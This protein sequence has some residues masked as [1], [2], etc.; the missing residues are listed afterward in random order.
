MQ[1]A[2]VCQIKNQVQA[3]AGAAKGVHEAGDV[4]V[5]R[6]RPVNLCFTQRQSLTLRH[7]QCHSRGTCSSRGDW[8]EEEGVLGVE[9]RRPGT[10]RACCV[11]LEARRR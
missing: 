1:Q 2:S 6:K 7:W 9:R 5:R 3:A 11:G 8:V 4:H 10:V